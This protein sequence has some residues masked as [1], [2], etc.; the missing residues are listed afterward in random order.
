MFGKVRTSESDCPPNTRPGLIKRRLARFYWYFIR[1]S[2][3]EPLSTSLVI[4]SPDR[5]PA[6]D[7]DSRAR[8]VKARRVLPSRVMSATLDLLL[9][10][11]SW[12]HV[13]LA[14]YTKVEESFNLHATHDVLMYGVGSD[15]LDKVRTQAPPRSVIHR[16]WIVRP[17]CFSW[18]GT[19]DIH[20][21]RAAC[22]DFQSRSTRLPRAWD[23]DRQSR[24]ASHRCVYRLFLGVIAPDN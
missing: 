22:L 12:T 24:D 19:Q 16:L 7:P 1:R 4:E 9:L 2:L 6:A 17:L 20:R 11:T 5:R 23:V 10:A 13:L 21:Q 18:G 3:G 15:V 8:V 14:P